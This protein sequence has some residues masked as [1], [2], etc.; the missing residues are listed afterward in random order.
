VVDVIFVELHAQ[1]ACIE[2]VRVIFQA[3]VRRNVLDEQ[4]TEPHRTVRE[5][6][7]HNTGVHHATVQIHVYP[8]AKAELHESCKRDHDEKYAAA[9]VACENEA[10][11][12]LLHKMV[13]FRAHV[14]QKFHA[15]EE[16]DWRD[17]NEIGQHVMQHELIEW[18]PAQIFVQRHGHGD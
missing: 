3:R 9:V 8:G 5:P 16:G 15:G 14:Q 2:T 13:V 1:T 17:A 6:N 4:K 11:H 10:T 7:D 12:H 18:L